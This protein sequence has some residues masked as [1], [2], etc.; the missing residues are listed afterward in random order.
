MKENIEDPKWNQTVKSTNETKQRNAQNETK[1]W[2]A[3][4]NQTM[5]SLNEIKEWNA[6]N[7]TEQWKAYMKPNNK[8]KCR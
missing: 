3:K 2:K 6:L 4:W 8:R 7:D 5:K 1:Q